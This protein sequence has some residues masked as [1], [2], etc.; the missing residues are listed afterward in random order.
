LNY[1]N[2]SNLQDSVIYIKHGHVHNLNNGNTIFN[3]NDYYILICCMQARAQDF[4]MEDNKKNSIIFQ[5]IF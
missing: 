5:L 1:G 4:F 2:K 3:K